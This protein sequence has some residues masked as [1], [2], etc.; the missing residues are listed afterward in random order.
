MERERER[1]KETLTIPTFHFIELE[2]AFLNLHIR[3][4]TSNCR[5]YLA[6][7]SLPLKPSPAVGLC[8]QP[9]SHKCMDSKQLLLIPMRRNI[10]CIFI[11]DCIPKD[12]CY[13]PSPLIFGIKSSAVALPD[14]N[15]RSKSRDQVYTFA[16]STQI[17][18]PCYSAKLETGFDLY[19]LKVLIG[20]R[21][22]FFFFFFPVSVWTVRDIRISRLACQSS[23]LLEKILVCLYAVYLEIQCKVV[24]ANKVLHHNSKR[25]RCEREVGIR[26][27]RFCDSIRLLK[28]SKLVRTSLDISRLPLSNALGNPFT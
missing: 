7:R 15:C 5:W 1:G 18:I 22:F 24:S 19:Q 13:Y 23:S 28:T 2:V 26:W 14:N 16:R 11:E 4:A 9:T 10:Q 3:E 17:R 25:G 20:K 12:S 8:Q 27:H 21:L 6:A